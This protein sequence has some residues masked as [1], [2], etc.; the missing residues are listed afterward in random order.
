MAKLVAVCRNDSYAFERRQIPLM[1]EETL[2]MV[3][4]IPETV[5]SAECVSS[6]DV[7]QFI[8]R[9]SCLTHSEMNAALMVGQK[10][11]FALLSISVP[12]VGCRRSVERLYNQFWE[13]GQPAI[14]PLI[15]TASG[16]LTLSESFLVDAK[17]IYALFY[18]HGSHLNDIVDTIPKSR[19]NRRCILHSLETHKSRAS[20]NW[21]DVW[22]L[23]SQD[24]RDEVVLIDSES[25]LDTLESYLRK[26]R[27]CSECKSKV[28][29]AYSI[30]TGDVDGDA[31]KGYC[32]GLYEGL[33]S[34]P[35]E[36]HVHV[37]CD[38]DFIAHLIGRA[39]P[40]LAGGRR[41]RHARTIDIAQEEVLTCLGIHLWERLHRLWQKLRAE[42]QTWQMLFYL[43]V[44][45][46]RKGFETAVEEKQGISQLELVVKEI[47]DA[48]KAKEQRK[49]NKRLKKKK[50]K[51][52]KAKQ[53]E[54][55]SQLEQK[56]AAQEEHEEKRCTDTNGVVENGGEYAESVDSEKSLESPR[57]IE[58]SELESSTDTHSDTSSI[59]NGASLCDSNDE[60]ISSTPQHCADSLSLPQ[61]HQDSN[62][63]PVGKCF[64]NTSSNSVCK[65]CL[66]A[67]AKANVSHKKHP[68]GSKSSYITCHSKD[69]S[70]NG[71][72]D[73]Y[74][75]SYTEVCNKKTHSCN[76]TD[77]ST[78]YHSNTGKSTGA[79]KCDSGSG[80]KPQKKNGYSHHHQEYR[81]GGQYK[82]YNG[83]KRNGY[84]DCN[85]GCSNVGPR[86]NRY[87][88]QN[89]WKGDHTEYQGEMYDKV[90]TVNGN[91]QGRGRGK[92]KGHN[93]HK[94]E[95]NGRNDQRHDYKPSWET[96]TQETNILA[97][98]MGVE[99]EG[100]LR[101]LKMMGWN[102]DD[103][104]SI[105]EQEIR[106]F[107]ANRPDVQTRREELRD[108]LREQF[109]KLCVNK[110]YSSCTINN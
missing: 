20:G 56:T 39:E 45:A 35:K 34:C 81:G 53:N 9:Y 14:E 66:Q 89:R 73:G 79:C 75:K 51:E 105:S 50:R 2:T 30:L 100:E 37:V 7:A 15:I 84:N 1:I 98:N 13:S 94:D 62:P 64:C 77:E 109:D 27:F 3:M 32:A 42:E 80:S 101:L 54:E 6:A 21:M 57:K 23:L 99:D 16:V 63:T 69:F 74:I 96:T 108:K 22:D 68:T 76:P 41:E 72:T 5:I 44:E 49:E 40:E 47:S 88:D 90:H 48:E 87:D 86:F 91:V 85:R 102:T 106:E 36:R 17:L 19:R 78:K 46:L 59:Q 10:E 28:L 83:Y 61:S 4:E 104:L 29:K 31:E 52:I 58:G 65:N 26:H 8:K 18:I 71:S 67:Q 38:T 24:C 11:L 103:S 93:K 95:W 55:K 92:R 110:I 97:G 43:G 25:L 12:C 70:N 33:K 60:R 107:S 82:L